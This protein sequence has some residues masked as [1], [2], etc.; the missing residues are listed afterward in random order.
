MNYRFCLV[1]ILFSAFCIAQSVEIINESGE[2]KILAAE[3]QKLEISNR[4]SHLFRSIPKAFN[5][6]IEGSLSSKYFTIYTSNNEAVKLTLLPEKKFAFS[7]SNEKINQLVNEELIPDLQNGTKQHEWLTKYSPVIGAAK[8][9]SF[10]EMWK[11]RLNKTDSKVFEKFPEIENYL[12]DQ[13]FIL[14]IAYSGSKKKEVN[15]VMKILYN[16]YYTKQLQKI[17]CK[18]DSRYFLIQY[19]AKNEKTN[20]LGL[21]KY[22]IIVKDFSPAYLEYFPT[23][24]QKKYFLLEK[25]GREMSGDATDTVA[26]ILSKYF[27]HID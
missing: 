10:M 27:N 24:C 16:K 6:F 26:E 9:Y 25:L 11:Q 2:N 13:S 18:S 22:P 1:W 3:F 7:G 17:N 5:I 14:L 19:L 15:D 20:A 21:A 8:F 23:D 12:F 4:K